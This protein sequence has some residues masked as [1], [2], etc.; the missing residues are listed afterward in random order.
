MQV[1]EVIIKNRWNNNK[2]HFQE[3]DWNLS[4]IVKVL[5]TH[6]L[7]TLKKLFLKLL[8]IEVPTDLLIDRGYIKVNIAHILAFFIN[9]VIEKREIIL[10]DKLTRC[11]F[12]TEYFYFNTYQKNVCEI[13]SEKYHKKDNEERRLKYARN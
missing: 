1:I 5:A 7:E 11:K 9:E 3:T 4:K 12:C 10:K 8:T 13:C 6:D 2:K